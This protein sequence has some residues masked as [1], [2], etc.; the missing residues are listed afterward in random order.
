ME[1]KKKKFLTKEIK[2]KMLGE[3]DQKKELFLSLLLPLQE[4]T[5][6]KMHCSQCGRIDDI[7]SEQLKILLEE[8][9]INKIPGN[10]YPNYYFE[11][12]ACRYC[13]TKEKPFNSF[14]IKVLKDL[15][16]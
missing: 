11:A 12:N 1:S 5:V 4:G 7:N 6:A 15:I 10:F 8:A 2:K 16:S 9:S 13:E 3:I 14:R